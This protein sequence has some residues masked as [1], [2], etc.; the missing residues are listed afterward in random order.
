MRQFYY[1]QDGESHGPVSPAEFRARGLPGTTLIWLAEIDGWKP[2]AEVPEL[3]GGLPGGPPAAPPRERQERQERRA[4]REPG[5]HV[6]HPEPA[7]VAP[8]PLPASP[9]PARPQPT[10]EQYR[11]QRREERKRDPKQALP[12]V[13]R[14]KGGGFGWW[15]LIFLVGLGWY[16][17]SKNHERFTATPDLSPPPAA[18]AP[19]PESVDPAE[20]VSPE[21]PTALPARS[22]EWQREAEEPLKH[23]TVEYAQ[24]ADLT[25]ETTISGHIRSAARA[26]TFHNLMV[27]VAF[28]NAADELLVKDWRVVEPSLAPGANV[29]FALPMTAPA[30]TAA[31]RVEVL[32]AEAE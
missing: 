20:A 3:A 7:P 14:P 18:T 22:A 31:V 1:A 24:P 9:A 21:A 8:G 28:L 32:K 26:A 15:R 13:A 10:K 25:G 23:L 17:W 4:A 27:Q 6:P 12:P 2:A 29:E 11:E 5:R 30:G 16:V 19:A